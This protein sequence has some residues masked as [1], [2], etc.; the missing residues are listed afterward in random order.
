MIQVSIG[1]LDRERYKDLYQV[2][3]FENVL[4]SV[5]RLLSL[6]RSVGSNVY[7]HLSFRTNNPNF[8]EM[9]REQL[10]AFKRQGCLVSHISRYG[11][12]GGI[13]N[14]GEVKN[15]Q[16]IDGSGLAKNETCVYLLLAPSVLP[17]G[18]I[19]NCGCVDVSGGSLIIGDA[20]YNSLRDCWGSKERKNI[21]DSF[22]QGKLVDL[23]RQCSMYRPSAHLAEPVYKNISSYQKLPLEFYMMYGG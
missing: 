13:V 15:A 23:C 20:H 8:E 5:S 2:D 9:H 10:E 14:S 19:T 1:G 4:N 17:N 12:F 6:K 3:Q 11:N 21:L 7:I 22:R 18:L 16:I